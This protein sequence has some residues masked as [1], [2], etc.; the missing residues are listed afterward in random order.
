MYYCKH[1]GEAYMTDEAV[2]CVKCGA[3]KGKG[4]NYCHNCGKPLTPGAQVCMTCGVATA[5][6]AASD[7]KSRVLA[8]VLAI[9]FGAF[10]V[11]N[12]YLGYTTRAIT[13]L[14]LTI[15][16]IP[17]CCFF[18]LGALLIVG[19]A[20]WGFVEGIMLFAGKIEKDGKGNPL[21]D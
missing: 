15:I 13:Q 17:L 19:I 21:K 5:S 12:F 14:V 16:G 9:L 1:C 11:H 7:A 20:I 2:L 4:E 6:V 10:G 3:P 8:G 18:G